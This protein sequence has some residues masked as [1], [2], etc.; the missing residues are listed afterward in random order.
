MS[1]VTA[2]FGC[3]GM[4]QSVGQTLLNAVLHQKNKLYRVRFYSVCLTDALERRRDVDSTTTTIAVRIS[5]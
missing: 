2:V 5:V 1:G 3:S 4:R